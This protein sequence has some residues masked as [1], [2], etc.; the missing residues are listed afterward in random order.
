MPS[1]GLYTPHHTS[2]SASEVTTEGFAA[3]TA[4]LTVHILAAEVQDITFTIFNRNTLTDNTV[5]GTASYPLAQSISTGY[6]ESRVPVTTPEGAVQG[7]LHIR[8]VFHPAYN[9]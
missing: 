1:L 6:E 4:F 3:L 9:V 8:A 5:I 7:S 2:K